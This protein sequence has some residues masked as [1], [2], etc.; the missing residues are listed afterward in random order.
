MQVNEIMTAAPMCCCRGEKAQQAANLM[1]QLN[2]GVIP[3]IESD[4]DETL[5]GL[6]TDRDL[7]MEVLADGTYP[8]EKNVEDCM[9]ADL[10]T[11]KIDD[12]LE[13]VVGLMQRH[14][15]RRI[16]V[17]DSDNHIQ[18]IVSL[19]DV[20]IMAHEHDVAETITEISEPF[21]FG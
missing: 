12:T 6:V 4:D 18:G 13:K 17:V 14:R 3:I 19:A 9:S 11:C 10:V 21:K 5:I 1:R 7:C 20:A 15:V 8:I 2:V 16:P